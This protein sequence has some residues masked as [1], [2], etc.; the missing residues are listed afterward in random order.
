M[1]DEEGSRFSGGLVMNERYLLQKLI[2]KG[3]FSEV[4][5][6]GCLSP[7]SHALHAYLSRLVLHALSSVTHCPCLS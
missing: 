1:K 5:Q 6:V 2:G 3:G 7:E 4:F